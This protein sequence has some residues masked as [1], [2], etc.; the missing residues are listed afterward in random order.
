[1]MIVDSHC[2]L[3]FP[4]FKEDFDEVLQ[5]AEEHEVRVMQT[6]CTHMEE[7]DEVRAIAEA[8]AHIYCSAG[9][10][11]NN[12]ADYPLVETE[13]L[14][15]ETKHPKVIGIGETGLD[16]YYDNSPR[17][18]QQESFKRHIAAGQ[19]TGLPI[20][21]H[22]RAADEDT[23]QILQDAMEEKPFKALIHCF[24]SS[25]WLAEECLKMGVYISIPGIVTFKNA[26]SLRESAAK[27]PLDRLLVETDAPYL[28]P[29]PKRG[30]RN[31]PA[32]TRHTAEKLAELKNVTLDDCAQATTENFFRLFDK[33]DA[34]LHA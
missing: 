8:H 32:F 11:P 20:I 31:E 24:S 27:V 25:W 2:H 33:V 15:E 17:E 3:N 1:M 23:V 16:Y 10:H 14:I 4:E 6:I 13:A 21:I 5:R 19:S 7:F 12:V 9:V 34:G 29:V 26:E 30:K 22:T 18:L 28:A